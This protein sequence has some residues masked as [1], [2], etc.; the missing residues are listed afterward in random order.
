VGLRLSALAAVIFMFVAGPAC[1]DKPGAARDAGT[2]GVKGD[3][4]TALTVEI[5]VTGCASYD[6]GPR[7]CTGRP[8]L[9]LSFSPVGSP[10]L[11]QFRWDFGDGTPGSTERAPAHTYAH[12]D[13][14]E[15]VLRGGAGDLGTVMANPLTI[16]VQPAAAGAPCDVD[17]QCGDGL[18]CLCAP[19][20]GCAAA[21]I[22]GVCSTTCASTACP[23]GATCAVVAVDAQTDGGAPSPLC[24]AACDPTAAG[25][26][27][28]AGFVCQ[29]LPAEPG[30][31]PTRWTHACL[32]LGLVSDLGGSCRNAD[33]VL[34]DGACATGSCADLGAL[35]VCTAECSDS[36]PCPAEAACAPLI[37]GSHRC[38]R[39]CQSDADCA[40]D[41]LL[42]CI[43][44]RAPSDAAPGVSVCAVRP[45]GSDTTCEPSGHCGPD[46]LCARGPR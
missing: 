32:P 45:C 46:G 38:L 6:A 12:P 33:D 28:P 4:P 9:G 24:L 27:C 20:M 25:A 5:A 26:T 30:T 18:T 23:T 29:T 22:R 35:G 44:L 40:R 8:P 2:D 16:E 43:A 11:T 34:V 13:T 41:P 37:D 31:A 39:T 1:R 10:D 21:F 19:G 3:G 42:A 14:Y 7:R 15:V 17:D 36:A